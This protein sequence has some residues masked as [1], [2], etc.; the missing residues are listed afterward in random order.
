LQI[1]LVAINPF[2]VFSRNVTSFK[3]NVSYVKALQGLCSTYGWS[4]PGFAYMVLIRDNGEREYIC[5]VFHLFGRW[6]I[7]TKSTIMS[8]SKREVA[9]DAASVMYRILSELSYIAYV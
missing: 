1:G 9:E 7:V 5:Y 3:H 4:E 8:R 6:A 2:L